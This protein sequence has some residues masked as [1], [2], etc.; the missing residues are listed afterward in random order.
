LKNEVEELESL[1]H[2]YRSKIKNELESYGRISRL[3]YEMD[4]KEA[5]A[6]PATLTVEKGKLRKY[7]EKDKKIS[8]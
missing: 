8:Q 2:H 6:A 1:N 4:L 3:A 5:L 7:A